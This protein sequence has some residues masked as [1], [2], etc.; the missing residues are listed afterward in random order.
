MR[1]KQI[2]IYHYDELNEQAKKKAREWYRKGHLDYD[3]WD[4]LYEDFAL[5]AQELG[6]DLIQKPVKLMNGKTRYDP[7]I[8]FS[9]F[10]HQGSGS[11]FG[12]T[13]KAW[14]MNLDKLKSECPTDTELHRIADVLASCAKEDG[15]ATATILPYRDTILPYRDNW[16][17]VT[18]E[19]GDT[20]TTHFNE[21]DPDS[22]EYKQMDQAFKAR[23]EAIT[24]ALRDFNRWMYRCLEK[25]YECLNS[26]EQVEESIIANEYEFTEDGLIA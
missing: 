19:D 15:E 20:L 26:D 8:Y 16:V 1:I 13:W 9:G 10:Y 24:E 4:C 25:E 14:E 22:P 6:I 11:S 12:G 5:R 7:A 17:N 18:V 2:K 21:L 3:W 23:E